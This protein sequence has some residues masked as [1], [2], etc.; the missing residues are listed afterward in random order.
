MI[1]D[2]YGLTR[3]LIANRIFMK[4]E[5][6]SD[7]MEKKFGVL[8]LGLDLLTTQKA[9]ESILNWAILRESRMVCAANVHMTIEAW[10][11][12][13]FREM[14]NRADMALIDGSGLAIG[15]SL[16]YFKLGRR[17]RGADL[18]MAV[19][20]AASEKGIKIGF[21]GGREEYKEKLLSFFK[22]RFPHLKTV[23][24]IVPPFREISEKEN[25]QYIE[26]LNRSG[27]RIVFVGIGCP[28]QEKWI[29]KNI[30]RV[31][32][33]MVGVG[34]AFD[35]FSGR[36]GVPPK[37]VQKAG[38]EWLFRLVREPRRM[39]KRNFVHSTRYIY[40]FTIQWVLDLFIA[41]K[42]I[43]NNRSA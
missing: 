29:S 18:M 1:L 4:M 35:Q 21:Y 22:E 6:L 2:C 19:C 26:Y 27:A 41:G 37:W 39:W 20:Q 24:F 38:I 13:E 14:I 42:R 28:K 36:I 23:S 11:N 5:K 25:E 17:T 7:A 16:K 9:V 43:L 30:N 32:A 8:G 10:D 34:G 40:L 3:C 33:V 31:Q 12:P 15:F